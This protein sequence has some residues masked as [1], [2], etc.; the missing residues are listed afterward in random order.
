MHRAQRFMHCCTP[1]KGMFY[2]FNRGAALSPNE[3]LIVDL[4]LL[5][6]D[7]DGD[8][9][10]LFV[11]FGL[12]TC[13]LVMRRARRLTPRVHRGVLD[14]FAARERPTDRRPFLT[15]GVDRGVESNRHQRNQQ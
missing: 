9:R 13:L 2:R 7:D 6:T 15:G 10:N 8:T 5:T 14:G 1:R 3:R 11:W 12:S 4:F